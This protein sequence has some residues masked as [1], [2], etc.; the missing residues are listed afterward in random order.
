VKKHE[1]MKKMLFFYKYKDDKLHLMKYII[2]N[3]YLR[4][5]FED[6]VNTNNN[7]NPGGFFYAGAF[8]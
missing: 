6:A 7:P 5:L 1:K 2:C 3:I 4:Q 8:A